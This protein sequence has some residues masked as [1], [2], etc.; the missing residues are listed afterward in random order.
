MSST[1]AATKPHRGNHPARP[2]RRPQPVSKEAL[3]H[4][5]RP[6]KDNVRLILFNACSTQ[7][8]T[9]AIAQTIECTVVMN[10]PIGDPAAIVFVA[11]FYRAIG[12]G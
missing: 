10:Q 2:E 3:V 1:S 9:E 11:S 8:Q 12:F 7:P 5:F 4:L 6:R